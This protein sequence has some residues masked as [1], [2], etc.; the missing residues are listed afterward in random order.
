MKLTTPVKALSVTFL[1]LINLYAAAQERSSPKLIR[2]KDN[3]THT[4]TGTVFPEQIIDYPRKSIYSFTKQ[5]DNIEVTY[6]SPEKA[7]VTIKLYPAGD[8]TEGRLRNEYLKSLQSI[9]NAVNKTIDF[10]QYPVRKTG[11]TFIC[12]GF[13]AVSNGKSKGEN[14]QLALYECGAWFLR[15]QITSKGL[16]S[17]GIKALEDSVLNRYDPTRLTALK[18]LNLKSDFIVAPGLGKDRV[19]A[20]YILQSGF[21]KLEWVNNN[22]PENERVSGFPDLYLNMHIAAFKELAACKDE[23]YTPDNHIAKFISGINK[24]IEAGYLPEFIMKQYSMVMIVPDNMQFDF[25]GFS[26][27][28]EQ[29]KISLDH[30]SLYYVII[31]RQP[32]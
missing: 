26:K 25:E 9:S 20:K 14:T 22:I 11:A 31:Y 10:D 27:W 24:V 5:D 23:Q 1:I 12:N 3:F 30:N 16:D 21:K 18:P 13:K 8:G 2:S 29:H 15:V 4:L 28:E 6:E 7:S 17:S 32:K 19:R